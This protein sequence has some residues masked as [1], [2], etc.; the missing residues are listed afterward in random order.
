MTTDSLRCITFGNE[1]DGLGISDTA[2]ALLDESGTVVGW[3]QAAERLVGYG[4]GD[5]VGC[6]AALVVPS[7]GAATTTDAF[8]ERLLAENGWPGA[9]A[10]RRHDGNLVDVSL[11]ITALPG[12]GGTTRW[13]ASLTDSGALSGDVLSTLARGPLLARAQIGVVIRDSHLRCMFAN[14]VMEQHDGVPVRR[15]L[16]RRLTESAPGA[17]AEAIEA[18][19]RQVLQGGDTKVH[20]YRAWLPAAPGREHSFAGAYHCLLGADGQTVGVCVISADVTES[21]RIRED[22]ATIA[23]ASTRL[24]ESLDVMQTSQGLADLAVPLL[25]DYVAVDLEQS[26][27]FGQEPAVHIG[28]D[29]GV[30][31]LRRAGQASIHRGVPDFPLRRG[32]SVPMSSASPLAAVLRTG[33]PHLEQHLER[34]W[35]EGRPALARRFRET[36]MHSLMVV[37]VHIQSALLG[38]VMFVRTE[39]RTPFEETDLLLAQEF[40]NRAAVALDNARRYAREQTAALTLQ[41]NLLPRRLTGGTAVEAASRYLPADMDHGVGGDWFDVIPLSGARVALVVGDVVGHGLHAAATMGT[42]RTAVRTLADMELPPDELLAHL[43]NTVQRMAEADGDDLNS[44]PGAVGATCLYAVYD[45]ATRVCA[46]ARAGHPPP[47]IV[48]REGGVTFPDLPPGAPLG[49]GLGDPF[50]TVEMEL[51]EG[52][53]L[54]LYTDGLI[55]TRDGDIEC[56]MRRLGAILAEPGRPLEEL[57]TRATDTVSGQASCDDTTLLLIRTRSLNA[58]QIASWTLPNDET[59]VRSARD[60]AAGQLTTWGLDSLSDS[61]KLIVSELVTNAVRHSTGPIR[62][63][64][65]RHG[66]LTC[67]LSD[68]DACAP[69]PRRARSTDENGR[70]LLLVAQMSRRWGSRL[71]PEGKVVWVEQAIPAT[72]NSRSSLAAT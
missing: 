22:L 66:V 64:L 52:S 6:S 65:K 72:S 28:A 14:D 54:A 43:D 35:V 21:R 48:D 50:E 71:V 26:V 31:V 47:A 68:S 45:P 58:A 32:E 4:A 1:F 5:I 62:L 38:V 34:P 49:V 67:E 19:M 30:P 53:L 46:M 24:S 27:P 57:C 25:A 37:P 9:S 55:E 33:K 13:L 18:L 15:R 29:R 36:G 12:Q 44:M 16:G 56:G 11:R 70:G 63:C 51:S 23:K 39:N 3:T 60:L 2:F 20:E 8:V 10:V 42:L 69:R 61:T 17:T 41:G 59:A 40:V 7:F